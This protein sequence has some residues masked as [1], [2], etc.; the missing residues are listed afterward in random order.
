MKTSLGED[1]SSR[2]PLRLWPGMAAAILL[3]L[4]RYALPLVVPGT[5]TI[6]VLGELAG[7]VAILVWWLFFSRARW[8]ARAGALALMIVAMVVTARFLHVSIAT[9]ALGMLFPL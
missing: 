2:E 9:G 5:G 7:S 6:G 4:A 3:A 8:I 1:E